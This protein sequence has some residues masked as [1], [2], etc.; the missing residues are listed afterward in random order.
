MDER[1]TIIKN[2][3]ALIISIIL[4]VV[5]ILFVAAPDAALSL[6]IIIPALAFLVY[7]V[8]SIVTRA[9]K[10]TQETPG[11]TLVL[12]V[13]AIIAGILLLV[14]HESAGKVLLPLLVGI[15]LIFDGCSTLINAGKAKEAQ[16]KSAKTLL[17]SGWVDVALGVILFIVGVS[18]SMAGVLV[19]VGILLIIYG[20]LSL[21]SQ[22]TLH[23]ARNSMTTPP[24]V[25]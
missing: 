8:V 3:A 24:R 7:G 9:V 11:K 10:K 18:G 21:I 15:W 4:L 6:I 19:F 5:G 2:N 25:K 23:S 20:L 13:I 16:L 1:R 12:P 17:V 22:L 14:F